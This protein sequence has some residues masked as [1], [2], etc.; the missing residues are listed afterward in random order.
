M[1]AKSKDLKRLL[2]H[3]LNLQ[4]TNSNGSQCCEDQNKKNEMAANIY[5]SYRTNIRS[6]RLGVHHR[7]TERRHFLQPTHEKEQR[8]YVF[9]KC[10]CHGNGSLDGENAI[11]QG[12]E[13]Y[14]VLTRGSIGSMFLPYK[15]ITGGY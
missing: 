4:N 8:S 7:Q 1:D 2:S 15:N 13:I 5:G 14:S 10:G 11:T 12:G 9:Q 6:T 3:V